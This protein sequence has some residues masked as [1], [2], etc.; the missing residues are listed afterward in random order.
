MSLQKCPTGEPHVT[1]TPPSPSDLEYSY[2]QELLEESVRPDLLDG[3]FP[4]NTQLSHRLVLDDVIT[5][6]K[7]YFRL[8]PALIECFEM[9]ADDFSGN[10]E[11]SIFIGGLFALIV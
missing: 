1:T 11:V 9:A 10:I 3:G 2:P 5:P 7:R 8:D 6:D 4:L